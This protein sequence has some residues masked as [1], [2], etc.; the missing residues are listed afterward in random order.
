MIRTLFYISLS[1]CICLVCAILIL[2]T[3]AKYEFGLVYHWFLEYWLFAAVLVL[4]NLSQPCY[5]LYVLYHTSES[6]TGIEYGRTT[7]C[8]RTAYRYQG[9]KGDTVLKGRVKVF[10]GLVVLVGYM[11]T[12]KIGSIVTAQGDWKIDGKYG[13]QFTGSS[14]EESLPATI[15]GIDKYLGSGLIQGVGLK[16][17]KRIVN[18]FQEQTLNVIENEPNRLLEVEGVGERMVG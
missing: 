16:F 12:V 11:P 3:S 8:G 15:Y 5:T 2:Y 9:R 18:K 10:R 17:A 13:R 4:A 1:S 14:W 6:E 7:L